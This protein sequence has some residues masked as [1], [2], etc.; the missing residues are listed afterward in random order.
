M[1]NIN[2]HVNM[3]GLR[4]GP[5]EVPIKMSNFQMGWQFAILNLFLIRQIITFPN[6]TQR[7][8]HNVIDIHSVKIFIRLQYLILNFT[9]IYIRR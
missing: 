8:N 1:T 6:F 5:Y 3:C 4:N 2:K 9:N 7:Y